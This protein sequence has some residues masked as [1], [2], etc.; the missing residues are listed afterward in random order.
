[1]NCQRFE[2]IVSELARGQMMAA[3]QRGEALAHSNACEHC[4]A[5]LRDEEMLTRGLRSLAAQMDHLAAPDHL[6][7]RLLE[8]FRTR[9]GMAPVR[10][11]RPRYWLAAVAAVL[12]IA[13]SLVALRWRSNVVEGPRQAVVVPSSPKRPEERP[14]REEPRRD[15][16]YQATTD[17]PR[18]RI[19]KPLRHRP[20]RNSGNTQTAT[21]NRNE[22]ATDFIPLRYMNAA[23]LQDGGQIVRVELP[24]STLA[25][26]GLPVNMD[27]Y[28]ERVKAD[29]LYGVDGL[30][31]AIRF[32]Q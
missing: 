11:S 30:A 22:I 8:A 23:N 18:Q 15:V 21:L 28:N 32:V 24:R 7:A 31:H 19:T 26:F 10:H 6:E 12:L 16:E 13:I 17:T 4:A 20:V 9:P 25:N 29:V 27:R 1:M 3:E 14:L 5:R 2:N